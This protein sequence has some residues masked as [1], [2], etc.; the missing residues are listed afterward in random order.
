MFKKSAI[1]DAQILGRIY[2]VLHGSSL[3]TAELKAAAPG[4]FRSVMDT[5]KTFPSSRRTSELELLVSS[6][7]TLN[8]VL[9]YDLE[10]QLTDE[11]VRGY[12]HSTCNRIRD[13]R[14][15]RCLKASEFAET[16]GVSKSY[17]SR[18]EEYGMPSAILLMK[19]AKALSCSMEDLVDP[20]G[21][22]AEFD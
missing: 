9:F 17:L 19:I 14:K 13:Q 12:R 10:G 18:I 11:F 3:T 1:R 2:R 21:I 4:A 7:S 8:P 20:E 15:A 5:Y 22:D 16:I 6:L